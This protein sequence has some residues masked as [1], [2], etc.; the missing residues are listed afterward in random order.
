M[1]VR[2]AQLRPPSLIERIGEPGLRQDVWED[3]KLANDPTVAP[4]YELLKESKP[5]PEPAN[6]RLSEVI[7]A[8]SP[9][10]DNIFLDEIG[11]EEGCAQIQEAMQEI[12]DKPAPGL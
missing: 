2:L 7:S 9:L 4:H 5:F 1:V 12:I 11:V 8:V 6:G 10:L 3:P